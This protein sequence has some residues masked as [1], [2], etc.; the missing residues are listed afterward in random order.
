MCLSHRAIRFLL[1][2]LHCLKAQLRRQGSDLVFQIGRP[3]SIIPS[4]ALQVLDNN[5]VSQ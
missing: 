1:E 5:Q 3:E 4:M 2:S